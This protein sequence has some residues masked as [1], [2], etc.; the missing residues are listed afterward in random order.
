MMTTPAVPITKIRFGTLT[1]EEW[2]KFAVTEI[3]RPASK[4]GADKD[5]GGTPYDERMGA[6]EN[7]KECLTCRFNNRDC[8]GHNGY[9]LLVEPVYNRQFFKIICYLLQS[10]CRSCSRPRIIPEDA[11]FAGLDR[12]HRYERLKDFADKCKSI[13]TCPWEDCGEPLPS[14]SYE[15]G[16]NKILM[17]YGKRKKA[18]DIQ[19][20]AAQAL[21]V[22]SKITNE[23]L[24][25]MGFN[26]GLNS[27]L[28]I[29]VAITTTK[30]HI[31]QFRPES[32][33]F[34]VLPVIP[35]IVRPFVVREEGDKCDDDLTEIYNSIIKLN[36][37]L[38]D[39]QF[40]SKAKTKRASEVSREEDLMTLRN[41]IWAI[42]DNSQEDSK[43]T[44]GGRAHKCLK[45]R[46]QGKTGHVQGN[47]GGK[48]V[49]HTA[50]TVIIGGGE[51]L[52]VD[53]VG[54]PEYIAERNT[55]GELVK[56]WNRAYLQKLMDNGK[57]N[58]VERRGRIIRVKDLKQFTL[59]IGDI[60][61]RQ[62]QDGDVVLLNRQPTLT[63]HSM[64]SFTCKILKDGEYA[65]R[66][67]L[68]YTP[69]FNADFD[70]RLELAHIC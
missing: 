64:I 66:L 22:F 12:F 24:K 33:I 60:A 7:G 1:A 58:R 36:N 19:F 25:V 62:L 55:Q 48:R 47:I 13:D 4:G 32:M 20:T 65:I 59:E 56:E 41:Q 18:E 6:L 10:V 52:R 49:D 27:E 35:P 70:G 37:R 30:D 28:P 57:V 16:A 43:V 51:E 14:F 63:P 17:Y 40:S 8:V 11:K 23:H 9:I 44:S 21:A 2:L 34:T 5:R 15:K 46:L 61:D 38:N 69:P 26:Q 54:I 50:R 45:S 68:A 31:H 39:N 53:Q 42:T 67:P 3:S 29:G